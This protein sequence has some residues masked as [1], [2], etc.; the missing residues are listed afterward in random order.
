MAWFK[1]KNLIALSITFLLANIG[2]GMAWPYLPVYIEILGGSLLA[3]GL[4]SI[5]YYIFASLFQY[6]WGKMSDKHHN[7]KIFIGTGLLGSGFMYYLVSLTVTPL[8]V[9][10]YRSI[11]GI[12]TSMSSPT[13]SALLVEMAGAHTGI[14]FGIFNS[15]SELG[16]TIGSLLGSAIVVYFHT[17]K[18][19]FIIAFAMLILSACV[20][21]IFIEEKRTPVDRAKIPF[22]VFRHE[23]KPGRMPWNIKEA[24][25][26]WK[27]NRQ[28]IIIFFTVFFVMAGSGEVYALL[29]IYFDKFGQQW[30][31]FLY[32]IEAISITVS[33]PLMGY[34]VERLGKR[35]TL[36]IGIIGYIITFILYSI[37]PTPQLMIIAELM[38][39]IKWSAFLIASSTYVASV[40]PK[41]KMGRGQALLN[42]AQTGGWVIGP[43]VGIIAATYLSLVLNFYMAIVFVF[44]GL[45]IAFI[46]VKE[47][48]TEK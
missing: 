11:Q 16:Y 41:D 2:W 43:I 14:Y 45:V 3:V 15:F 5:L 28:I 9:L 34:V 23:G 13:S 38:S 44:I 8:I 31:G 37:M 20:G 36:L 22:P 32:G 25:H 12:V 48:L 10:G 46:Y 26:L 24:I 30:I 27:T 19:V 42:T 39:G 35:I 33:M 4:L 1:D 40:S 21:I 18:A 17:V 29:P 6:P 7:R 47:P